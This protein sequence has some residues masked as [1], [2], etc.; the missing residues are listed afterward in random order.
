[1]QTESA[2]FSKLL[3]DIAEL[4]DLLVGLVQD[5]SI[6]ILGRNATIYRSKTVSTAVLPDEIIPQGKGN[7]KGNA[8]AYQHRQ[9]TRGIRWLL[10]GEEEMWPD[11][12]S[13]AVSDK[14]LDEL[15]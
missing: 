11:D 2:R 12:V 7:Y 6:Q 1:M 14:D 3:I 4:Q 10:V 13:D 15:V 9:E 5:R 8:K